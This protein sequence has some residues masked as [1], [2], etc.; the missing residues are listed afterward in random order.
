MFNTFNIITTDIIV[1]KWIWH[2]INQNSLRTGIY[3]Y[4]AK[5]DVYNDNSGS[6]GDLELASELS[7]L[8]QLWGW[9]DFVIKK[10]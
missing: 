4:R 5:N 6:L 8:L 2:F 1:N 7:K 10:L 9:M 3:A